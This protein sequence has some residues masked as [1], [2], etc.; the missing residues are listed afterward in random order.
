MKVTQ[1]KCHQQ[2]KGPTRILLSRHLFFIY[3]IVRKYNNNKSIN[4]FYFIRKTNSRYGSCCGWCRASACVLLCHIWIYEGNDDRNVAPA[5]SDQLQYVL[6]ICYR[7]YRFVFLFYIMKNP[8]WKIIIINVHL[9]NSYISGN[10]HA[11]TR[12]HLKSHRSDKATIANVQFSVQIGNS[13]YA[14][15]IQN[16]R[17]SRFLS[18]IQYAIDHEFTVPG[19]T[20][21]NVWILSKY[22]Q[23]LRGLYYNLYV[24]LLNLIF[25]RPYA[26][27]SRS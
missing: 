19:D 23:Y 2:S 11:H 20:L 14:G 17:N 15:R 26:V 3:D 16:G 22:G 7:F 8:I 6:F 13:V 4:C 24:L 10:S 21:F 18:V 25:T 12:C 5:Q 9:L 1:G 27:K